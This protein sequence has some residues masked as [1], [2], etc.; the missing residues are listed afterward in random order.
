M[1]E[2]GVEVIVFNGKIKLDEKHIEEQLGHSALRKATLQNSSKLR[3]KRTRTTK[4]W[5]KSNL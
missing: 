2:N 3:K 5:R 1:G 4:M